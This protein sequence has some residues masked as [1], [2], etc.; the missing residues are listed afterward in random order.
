MNKKLLTICSMM[1]VLVVCNA[2]AQLRVDPVLKTSL[3]HTYHNWRLAMVK[4]NYNQWVQFTAS[5]RQQHIKNRIL[6]EKKPFP[7]WLFR[8]PAAPPSL[9]GLKPLSIAA[10]GSTATAVY[11]GRVDFGVGGNPPENLL[12]LSFVNERGRWKYD[13]ADFI[14]LNELPDV[15]KQI[16]AGDYTYV[17]NADFQPSGVI[18]RPPIPVNGAKYIAKVYVFCPGREVKMKVNNISN[19]RFQNTE[20]SE[21]VIGGGRDGSNEVQFTTK[22]LEGSTGKERL[23][24]SIFLMSTVQGVKPIQIFEEIWKEN[25]PVKAFATKNFT[26]DAAVINKLNGK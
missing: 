12:L 11:F 1:L 4:Q 9:A 18:P 16:K 24:I 8:V 23:R 7:A 13:N 25:E 2:T 26:I 19:H 5:H 10:K 17:K 3:E 14:R 15:R 6:S 20:G 21:V 22:S